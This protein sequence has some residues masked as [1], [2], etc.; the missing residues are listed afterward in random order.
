MLD[1]VL[2]H[3][4]TLPTAPAVVACSN[5]L[6]TLVISHVAICNNMLMPIILSRGI[7]T[8]PLK[9]IDVPFHSTY[10]LSSVPSYRKFL[11]RYI[12]REDVQVDRLIDKYIP[13]L[14]AK[15]FRLDDQFLREVWSL[16]GSEILQEMVEEGGACGTKLL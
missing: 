11:Q 7:A 5:D 12:S 4:H 6:H 9:G 1:R 8:I 16:T 10:L 3:L 15:P 13:N 2:N 14:V